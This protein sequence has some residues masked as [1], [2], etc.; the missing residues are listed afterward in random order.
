[1]GNNENHKKFKK[2]PLKLFQGSGSESKE[3]CGDDDSY[4]KQGSKK[5]DA[6]ANVKHNNSNQNSVCYA[7]S[8]YNFID[9]PDKVVKSDLYKPAGDKNDENAIS[10]S[11]D[12]YYSDRK[13]GYIDMNI[14]AKTPIY[15]R[16]TDDNWEDSKDSENKSIPDFFSPANRYRI[17]GSSLRGMTRTILEILSYGKFSFF[18][19]ESQFF[20]RSFM[21]KSLDLQERYTSIMV[22]KVVHKDDNIITY[23][24]LK[25]GYLKKKGHNNYVI[26]PAETKY[27]EEKYPQI[28]RVEEDLL[29][30]KKI[31]H[32]KMSNNKY[33]Q[34]IKDISFIPVKETDHIHNEKRIKI[35]YAKV[36]DVAPYDQNEIKTGEKGGKE[37]IYGKLICSG[38]VSGTRVGKHMHWIIG[39]AGDNSKELSVSHDLVKKYN[40]DINRKNDDNIDLIKFSEK[41]DGVPCFYITITGKEKVEAFGHTGMFRIPYKHKVGDF[42]PVAH[43]NKIIDIPTAIFGNETDFAGRVYFEDAYLSKNSENCISKQEETLKILSGPK[44]TSFQLYLK[45]NIGSVTEHNGKGYKGICNYNVDPAKTSIRGYKLYWHKSGEDYIETNDA[46][47]ENHKSQYVA[48][49]VKTVN[50]G[51]IFN[52]RI[53]FENLTDIELGALLESLNLK[54]N[55]AHKIGLGKPLGLGSIKINIKLYLSDR[56]K[57]YSDLLSEWDEKQ[58]ENQYVDFNSF[59]EK[60]ERY[61]LSEIYNSNESDKKS[62]WNEKRIKELEKMLDFDK[63]PEDK[64]TEYMIM[65]GKDSEF[66]R[67]CILRSP[68]DYL[69]PTD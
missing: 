20:Y 1:M 19:K 40:G 62:F 54:S 32:E 69:P 39:P 57:R 61:I 11:S 27:K 7:H 12:K 21:D 45:Q 22:H 56:N 23:P 28:F 64:D 46:N 31:I 36:T 50:P 63:K 6:M 47:I 9:L 2:S 10:T 68:I 16:D 5:R 42:L 59:I 41:K 48:S 17:P 58:V 29:L 24:D 4:H 26:I 65:R 52:G 38:W 15:I 18:N 51:A 3:N 49:K 53:R 44:P 60:F 37:Y 8:P 67:R 14:T 66:K 55:M 35:R 30:E 33:K 43:K 25:A 34:S 13:T